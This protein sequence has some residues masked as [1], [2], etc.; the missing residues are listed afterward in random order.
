MN[1]KTVAKWYTTGP[2]LLLFLGEGN[3]YFY[4]NKLQFLAS[5]FGFAKTVTNLD[6]RFLSFWIFSLVWNVVNIKKFH[7]IKYILPSFWYSCLTT[8]FCFPVTNLCWQLWYLFVPGNSYVS[9]AIV[10]F[11]GYYSQW[12]S[13][14]VS[15]P[16]LEIV[17]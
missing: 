5:Y 11:N 14:W 3:C 9:W 4:L 7:W 8:W 12:A 1:K 2:F 13:W 16:N 15:H 17:V 6:K 10:S